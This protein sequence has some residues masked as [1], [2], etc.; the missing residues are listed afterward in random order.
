MEELR[1]VLNIW[2]HKFFVAYGWILTAQRIISWPYQNNMLTEI[3]LCI[4]T[5]PTQL[6]HR[7]VLTIERPGVGKHQNSRRSPA[8]RGILGKTCRLWL[9]NVHARS[10]M[11]TPKTHPTQPIYLAAQSFS[12]Q[13]TLA[14][15]Y[16]G[17]QRY[18]AASTVETMQ[19]VWAYVITYKKNKSKEKNLRYLDVH[20]HLRLSDFWGVRHSGC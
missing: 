5:R 11:H 17:T 3:A 13:Q 16:P 18:Q 2:H 1:Y 10:I 19:Q 12:W 20:R 6:H 15:V 7:M 8:D 14:R 4:P 9:H